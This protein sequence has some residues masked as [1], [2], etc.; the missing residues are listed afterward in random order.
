LLGSPKITSRFFSV[1]IQG[2]REQGGLLEEEWP[3]VRFE[4]RAGTESCA[5]PV[6]G[7]YGFNETTGDFSLRGQQDSPNRVEPNTVAFMLTEKAPASGVVSI[8]LLDVTSGVELEEK[9]AEVSLV[10]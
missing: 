6:S 4:V 7:T 8:R 5:I 10:F 3:V 1:Q 9:D 2:E